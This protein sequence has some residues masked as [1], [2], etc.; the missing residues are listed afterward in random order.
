MHLHV[1]LPI[2]LWMCVNTTESMK[3]PF[4][5]AELLDMLKKMLEDPVWAV[6]VKFSALGLICSLANSSMCLI[7]QHTFTKNLFNCQFQDVLECK[8]NSKDMITGIRPQINK[9][10]LWSHSR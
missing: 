1:S 9:K 5:D 8:E 10:Y 4:R 3:D 6:E 7:L 2:C